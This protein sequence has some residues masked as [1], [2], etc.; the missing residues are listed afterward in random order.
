VL[1]AGP[2]QSF[3]NGSISFPAGVQMVGA[4]I[5]PTDLHPATLFGISKTELK[6][7]RYNTTTGTYDLYTA[8]PLPT[9]LRMKLGAG[10]FVDLPHAVQVTPSGSSAPSG[11][12]DVVLKKGWQQLGN[13]FFGALDFSA[14]TVTVNGNTMDL[15]SAETAGYLRAYCWIYNH[16]TGDYVLVHPQYG[17][18][19]DVPAWGGM[20]VYALKACTLTLHRPTGT[21]TGSDEAAGLLSTSGDEWVVQLVARGSRGADTFN[22]CGVRTSGSGVLSPPAAVARPELSF[23]SGAAR[24]ATAFSATGQAELG[25]DMEVRWPAGEG[26]VQVLWPDLSSVPRDYS[27]TL[28]DVD[29]GKRVSMRH[30]TGYAVDTNGEEGVRHLRV[31]ATKSSGGGVRIASVSAQSTGAGAQVAFSLSTAASC[32][33]SVVNIAGRPI[34]TVETGRLRAAGANVVLWDG[35]SETGTSVPRGSYLVRVTAK[36]DDGTVTSALSPLRLTR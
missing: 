35:R 7:A 23:G 22:Y 16:S 13:P 10:F 14:S 32:E 11:N 2:V 18:V 20:W 15:V 34:R 1:D 21:A 8:D 6:Y 24:V 28:C 19:S 3:A 29:T 17:A 9:N 26:T 4:P 27:L 5:I 30:Q 33:V 25:W 31:E 12:F 36:A